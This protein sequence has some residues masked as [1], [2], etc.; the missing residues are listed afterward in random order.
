ML[1]T[2]ITV[3]TRGQVDTAFTQDHKALGSIPSVGHV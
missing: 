2:T 3:R 1:L